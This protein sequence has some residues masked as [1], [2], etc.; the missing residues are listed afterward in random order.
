[1]PTSPPEFLELPPKPLGNQLRSAQGQQV[2]TD[3]PSSIARRNRPQPIVFLQGVELICEMT[4]ASKQRSVR[5]DDAL[6]ERLEQMAEAENRTFRRAGGEDNKTRAEAA[7]IADLT[8]D[9]IRKAMRDN[10]AVREFYNSQ[11]KALMNFEGKSGSR[12][13]QGARWL[14]CRGP[15]R[16]RPHDPRGSRCSCTRDQHA[17]SARLC[18]LDRRCPLISATD[19]DRCH[20]AEW[21]ADSYC[22]AITSGARRLISDPRKSRVRGLSSPNSAPHAKLPPLPNRSSSY[23]AS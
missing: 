7:K 3:A 15:R 9:A 22:I 10:G 18:D 21:S 5:F 17:A 2:A 23:G 16:S 8:E 14:E 4:K 11:V 1:M 20:A 6:Q 12:A 19:A 13:D